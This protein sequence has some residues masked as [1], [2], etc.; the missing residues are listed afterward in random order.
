MH[1][2]NLNLQRPL[3]ITARLP[4]FQEQAHTAGMI[5]HSVVIRDAVEHVNPGQ[6][7]VIAM[8]QP[9]FALEKQIQWEFP[10]LYGEDKY[11]EDKY[12]I[13]ESGWVDSSLSTSQHNYRRQGKCNV[14]SNPCNENTQCS[15]SDCSSSVSA[16]DE[17]L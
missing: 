1:L 4:L 8:D 7:P 3:V 5:P 16:A 10:D 17:C 14:V 11:G 9:L 12:A 13:I 6:I 2:F 15:S